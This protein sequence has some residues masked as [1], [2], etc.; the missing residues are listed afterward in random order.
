MPFRE[1]TGLTQGSAP[2]DW[3]I[4]PCG[5]FDT[6]GIRLDVLPGSNDYYQQLSFSNSADPIANATINNHPLQLTDWHRWVWYNDG[7][8]LGHGGPLEIALTGST[9]A[10]RTASLP[11]GLQLGVQFHLGVQF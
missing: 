5:P 8:P 4:V 11:G 7:Q 10:V 3:F 2:V 6:G 9:G 1:V